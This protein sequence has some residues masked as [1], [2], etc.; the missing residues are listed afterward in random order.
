MQ[1]KYID[2]KQT[3]DKHK[4]K[5]C[6]SSQY[7]QQSSGRNIFAYGNMNLP[8]FSTPSPENMPKQGGSGDLEKGFFSKR[9]KVRAR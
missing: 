1:Y 7:L 9:H 2:T 3:K 8:I 4:T 5:D 6:Q